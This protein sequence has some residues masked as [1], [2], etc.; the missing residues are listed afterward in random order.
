MRFHS[1]FRWLIRGSHDFLSEI[2]GDFGQFS[3]RTRCLHNIFS[4]CFHYFS[5]YLHHI[6]TTNFHHMKFSRHFH[7]KFTLWRD[8]QTGMNRLRGDAQRDFH[9]IFTPQIYTTHFHHKFSPQNLHYRFSPRHLHY[10][11]SP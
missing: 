2:S 5:L 11:F 8:E 4:P 3:P 9:H 7:H 6:Y 1:D 10:R